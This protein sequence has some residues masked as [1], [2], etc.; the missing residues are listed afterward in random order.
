MEKLKITNDLSK[1]EKRVARIINSMV[2]AEYTLD[3]LI[4]H[5]NEKGCV[6][7]VVTELIS[8]I[9][10]ARFYRL[11]KKEIDQLFYDTLEVCDAGVPHELIDTWDYADPL[12]RDDYN[13]SLLA[14]FG[15]EIVS[16]SL[17]WEAQR[18]ENKKGK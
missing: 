9:D 14:W 3:S 4:D 18:T 7:G 1:F 16:R 2:K 13:Q 15:F 17:Q 10:S 12:A 8:T 5:I 6:S 11:Y